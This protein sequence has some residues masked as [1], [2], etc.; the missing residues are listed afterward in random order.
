[1]KLLTSCILLFSSSAI[2]Q[3]TQSIIHE[4]DWNRN[5]SSPE[6]GQIFNVPMFNGNIESLTRIWFRNSITAGG[7][8]TLSD[9]A[10]EPIELGF[11]GI[12]YL[13]RSG[14]ATMSTFV[15]LTGTH[16]LNPSETF[17]H[18]PTGG[19]TS[20]TGLLGGFENYVGDESFNVWVG[21]SMEWTHA[22]LAS[23]MSVFA[24]GTVSVEYEY[25]VSAL[26]TVP[27]PASLFVLAPLTMTRRRR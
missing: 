23:S 3:Q 12:S 18:N 6:I 8:Y 16:I 22:D 11:T 25:T 14:D 10:V 1:M 19:A 15:S 13:S 27:T 24:F 17:E 7:T 26:N 21:A 5:I 9:D 4:F 20:G 2:A